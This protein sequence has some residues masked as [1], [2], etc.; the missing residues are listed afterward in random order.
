MSTNK[1]IFCHAPPLP[2]HRNLQRRTKHILQSII[3]PPISHKSLLS[4]NR[5]RRGNLKWQ[6]LVHRLTLLISSILHQ[7]STTII[8]PHLDPITNWLPTSYSTP[9][10]HHT[11]LLHT[12]DGPASTDDPHSHLTADILFD[13]HENTDNAFDDYSDINASDSLPDNL[14]DAIPDPTTPNNS[15]QG[16]TQLTSNAP[17]SFTTT[18]V[19]PKKIQYSMDISKIYTQNIHGLWCRSRDSEGNIIPNSERDNT[20][21]EHLIH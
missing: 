5:P 6:Q 4:H 3:P 12:T 19:P 10:Y 15:K 18:V 1:H 2:T 7:P 14:P 8:L 20:K 13:S 21:L 9:T 11:N 16:P 17:T